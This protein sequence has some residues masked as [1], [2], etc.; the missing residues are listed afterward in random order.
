MLEVAQALKQGLYL[1]NKSD[2]TKTLNPEEEFCFNVKVTLFLH[3]YIFIFYLECLQ[4]TARGRVQTRKEHL[5]AITIMRKVKIWS[6]N[7]IL[8]RHS[9]GKVL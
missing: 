7:L 6:G 4:S 5:V 2:L 1:E 8:D 9:C 3:I